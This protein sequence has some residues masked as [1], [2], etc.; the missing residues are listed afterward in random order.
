MKTLFSMVKR[1]S[2]DA[3]HFLYPKLCLACNTKA[4]IP[5]E[6]IC[7]T[8]DF[9]LPKTNFHLNKENKLTE[10]FWGRTKIETGAALYFFKKGSRTQNLIHNLKYH[11][12]SE[13]GIILGNKYGLDLVKSPHYKNIDLIIPVPLHWKK[14]R[15]RGY[16]QSAMF[17]KGLSESMQVPFLPH[18]LVRVEDSDSQTKKSKK[19]RLRNVENV[20]QV[21]PPKFLENKHILL[22]DDVLTSGATLEACTIAILNIPHTQVSLATIAVAMN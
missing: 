9:K 21:Q 13:I 14:Q 8:C 15:I 5:K 12:K 11:G 4:P 19:K 16:N 2:L 10:R 17:A 22:V 1:I 18:G 20:F 6:W 3:F 7:M